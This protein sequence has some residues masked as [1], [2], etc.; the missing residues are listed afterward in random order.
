MDVEDLEGSYPIHHDLIVEELAEAEIAQQILDAELPH[1]TS[2]ADDK[3]SKAK[4]NSLSM[5]V[6]AD[7]PLVANAV[8]QAEF[9][10]EN[11]VSK[12][13][14]EDDKIEVHDTGASTEESEID[15]GSLLSHDPS[16]EEADP[17]WL[18]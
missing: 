3:D 7:Y 5:P 9:E 15:K 14:D 2:R 12:P 6:P 8:G 11:S 16:D 1:L 10:Q 18:A 17:E 13:Q 4:N